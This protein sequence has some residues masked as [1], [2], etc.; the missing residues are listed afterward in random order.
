MIIELASA[1]ERPALQRHDRHVSADTLR[2]K[3]ARGE[4][5]VA[6]DGRAVIGWVRFGWFWDT[7]PF[8][9]QIG[10]VASR[11]GQGIGTAMMTHWE[12]RMRE[13]GCTAALVSTQADEQAQHFYRKLGYRDVG[14]FVLPGEAM[15][16]ILHKSL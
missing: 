4:V 15:E 7:I 8:V 10:V 14:G 1:S 2:D 3:I 16:L 13:A 6:R 11:R 12:Q 5:L 9:Y